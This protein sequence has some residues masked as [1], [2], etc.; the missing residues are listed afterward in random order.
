MIA[1]DTI[2]LN[3][4]SSTPWQR[5]RG[6][7]VVGLIIVIA[8]LLALAGDKFQLALRYDRMLIQQGQW[9]RLITGHLVHGNVHHAV[10]N[11]LGTALMAALFNRTYR[12]KS[13]AVIVIVTVVSIDLG[14]WTLM[15]QLEWYVGLSGVLHGVLAAG[16]IAW[17]K[18]E[19]RILAALLT[20]IMIGK[21]TWEQ[22]QGAL[23]LS[24]D[25]PVVVNAHLYGALGGLLGAALCWRNLLAMKARLNATQESAQR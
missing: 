10:L 13:W 8:L 16:A 23:P 14:F 24:G 15:P 25:L 9:W 19:D 7:A 4:N 2:Q 12:L 20:L 17:W 1:N 21:L 22:T 11:T 5:L 6:W 18:T 3:D